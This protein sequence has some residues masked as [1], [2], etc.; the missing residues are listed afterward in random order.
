MANELSLDKPL[1]Y[2]VDQ[3]VLIYFLYHS[4]VLKY[5]LKIELVNGSFHLSSFPIVPSKSSDF[6]LNIL[7]YGQKNMIIL[8]NTID[9]KH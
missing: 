9:I 5:F 3:C 7:N 1:L 2:L 8:M 4:R 6:L